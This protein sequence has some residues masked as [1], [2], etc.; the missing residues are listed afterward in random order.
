MTHV[1]T[2][3]PISR[4]TKARIFQEMSSLFLTESHERPC[5]GLVLTAAAGKVED[6]RLPQLLDLDRRPR[7]PSGA[8]RNQSLPEDVDPLSLVRAMGTECDD[9][10]LLRGFRKDRPQSGDLASRKWSSAIEVSLAML[11]FSR[12]LHTE[13]GD[14]G[15][16]KRLLE[17]HFLPP[18][19]HCRK[20]LR[21]SLYFGDAAW[22]L[23]KQCDKE[24]AA[25]LFAGF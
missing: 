13:R 7:L 16:M 4:P 6:H 22:I 24:S 2:E 20:A 1:S 11:V 10:G 18:Q 12:E 15:A 17:L 25:T 5:E 9:K 19:S 3:T 8:S 23:P 21:C 14:F